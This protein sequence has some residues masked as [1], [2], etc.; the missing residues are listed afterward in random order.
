MRRAGSMGHTAINGMN[1]NHFDQDT[2][3]IVQVR[4]VHGSWKRDDP[5]GMHIEVKACPYFLG[6][7]FDMRINECR[8]HRSGI[9]TSK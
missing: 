3:D 4:V 9:R 8:T 5:N 6:A 2:R 7:S 1:R